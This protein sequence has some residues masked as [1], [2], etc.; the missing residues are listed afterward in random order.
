MQGIAT[1]DRVM[2]AVAEALGS[3]LERFDWPAAY[4]AG[5]AMA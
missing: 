5:S 4:S 3:R 1:A 2:A